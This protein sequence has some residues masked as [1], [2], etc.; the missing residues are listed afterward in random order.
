LKKGLQ[1]IDFAWDGIF[2]VGVIGE[3]GWG[4]QGGFRS[5]AKRISGGFE[6][7]KIKKISPDREHAKKKGDAG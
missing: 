1:L 7:E 5:F 2:D 4:G 6:F 3:F